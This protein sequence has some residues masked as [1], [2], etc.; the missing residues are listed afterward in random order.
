MPSEVPDVEGEVS[1]GYCFDVEADCGDCGYDFANFEAVEEGRFAGVV[2]VRVVSMVVRERKSVNAPP[3]LRL[4]RC[5]GRVSRIC[6]NGEAG[7]AYKTENENADLL[8]GEE[9][10]GEP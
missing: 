6:K 10:A 9:E 7:S 3:L 5:G 4:C 1:I 8:F 2:L